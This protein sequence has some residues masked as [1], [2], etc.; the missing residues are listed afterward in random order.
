MAGA[1]QV[2]PQQRNLEKPAL[3]EKTK[4]YRDVCQHHRRVHIA[5][6]IGNEY[7]AAVRRNLLQAFYFH[8][9]PASPQ[10][11]TR[12]DACHSNLLAPAG[13]E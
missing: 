13:L 4:L 1:R 9:H 7:V 11:K 3:S 5:Q 2:R 8:P 10:Q 12:P 6:M